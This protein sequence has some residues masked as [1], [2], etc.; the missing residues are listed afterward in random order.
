MGENAMWNREKVPVGVY[1]MPHMLEGLQEKLQ[2]RFRS[3]QLLV[4]AL[5][6]ASFPAAE[7]RPYDRLEFL[8]DAIV[9]FYITRYLYRAYPNHTPG[10]LTWLKRCIVCNA[11][12]A[13][14]AV[15]DFQLHLYLFR[16][17]AELDQMIRDGV[18]MLENLDLP[19][20][21]SDIWEHHPP[22]V[23]GD[24]LESV[25]GAVHV[26]SGYDLE[27]SDRVCEMIFKQ[28]LEA[29]R[30]AKM[31]DPVQRLV[32]WANKIWQCT[33]VSFTKR[34]M[35]AVDLTVHEVSM[36]IHGSVIASAT[37]RN[38]YVAKC[39][40]AQ[41]AL[42]MLQLEARMERL[43]SCAEGADVNMVDSDEE[44]EGF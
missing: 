1:S 14:I 6:H 34:T 19:T 18:D 11:T 36:T 44:V 4:E 31:D 3:P 7:T 15:R 17:S 8:G 21:M 27:V 41:E 26:D 29:L 43:C 22:K 42:E 39:R 33:K 28:A 40:A 5:T 16:L 20:M 9:D 32:M 37:D 12:L 24:L 10:Q 30:H 38:K 23:L 35:T 13:Y 2:Y 25:L